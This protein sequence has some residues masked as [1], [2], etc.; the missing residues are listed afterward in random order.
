[1]SEAPIFDSKSMRQCRDALYRSALYRSSMRKRAGPGE[2]IDT[3]S[4]V[5]WNSRG[6]VPFGGRRLA[7]Y[8]ARGRRAEGEGVACIGVYKIEAP[9]LC[10]CCSVQWIAAAQ[11]EARRLL[12]AWPLQNEKINGI[13]ERK[14]K[15]QEYRDIP[16]P[17]L[18]LQNPS[19]S[20]SGLCV[21][22]LDGAR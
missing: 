8:C 20:L 3:K 13:K 17:A 6:I 12:L 21:G 7:A 5:H 14:R 22:A 2:I 18:L 15:M 9:G 4:A 11:S 10:T 19:P 16:S 1:M